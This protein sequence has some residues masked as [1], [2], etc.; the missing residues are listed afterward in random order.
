MTSVGDRRDHMAA[1]PLTGSG[2]DWCMSLETITASG[3][4]V[5]THSHFVAPMDLSTFCAGLPANCRVVVFQPTLDGL[6]VLLVGATQWFLRRKSPLLQIPADRPDRNRNTVAFFDPLTDG[7]ARPQSKG[8]FQ[9]IGTSVGNQTNNGCGL[10]TGQ[11][12]LMLGAAFVC[13]QGRIAPFLMRL[14]PICTDVRP[15]PKIRQASV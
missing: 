14:E 6:R 1:K 3:L 8:K 5:R 4:R 15:T 11:T 9:L 12:R 13:L 7:I 2:N 10:M